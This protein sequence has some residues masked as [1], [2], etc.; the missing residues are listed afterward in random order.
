MWSSWPAQVESVGSDRA[1]TNDLHRQAIDK[2]EF[3]AQTNDA[4]LDTDVQYRDT[5]VVMVATAVATVVLAI[6]V[7]RMAFEVAF[8]S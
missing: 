4:D 2:H 6:V 8:A 7:G 3:S 5:I 1:Q